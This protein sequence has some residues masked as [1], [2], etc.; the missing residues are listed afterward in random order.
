MICAGPRL[1][2]TLER[3]VVSDLFRRQL[4]ALLLFVSTQPASR[5]I[6]II[7][8]TVSRA[9]HERVV[10]ILRDFEL[11]LRACRVGLCGGDRDNQ[12]AVLQAAQLGLRQFK[13]ALRNIEVGLR[14]GNLFGA[15][16]VLQALKVGLG[17]RQRCFQATVL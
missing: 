12:C 16:A 1:G 8:D 4:G 13:L 15:R 6:E 3:S 2:H 7:R 14:G 9:E 10:R 5:H 11:G 17:L